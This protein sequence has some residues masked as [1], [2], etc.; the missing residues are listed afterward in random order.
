M[1]SCA[2]AA[3]RALSLLAERDI[4]HAPRAAM[5][6]PRLR[7]DVARGATA[8]KILRERDGAQRHVRVCRARSSDDDAI[9]FRCSRV[10]MPLS[11]FSDTLFSTR[12]CS[13]RATLASLMRRHVA[14]RALPRRFYVAVRTRHAQS[15]LAQRPPADCRFADFHS[16]FHYF[17]SA[18][19]RATLPPLRQ[20][21]LFDA[22][23]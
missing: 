12:L 1:L 23:L 3:A 10:P 4:C 19:F 2:A 5:C 16:P 13:L 22:M 14:V 9:R 11:I 6:M 7:R 15:G 8:R 21:F 18:L 20:P 17:S